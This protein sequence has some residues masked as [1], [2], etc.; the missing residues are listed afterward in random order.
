MSDR[1]RPSNPENYVK[2]KY[3]KLLFGR[4]GKE[5]CEFLVNF[6]VFVYFKIDSTVVKERDAEDYFFWNTVF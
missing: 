2:V 5:P 4:F 3:F 1:I 6:Y